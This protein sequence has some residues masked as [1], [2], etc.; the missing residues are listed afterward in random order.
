[1][2][3]RKIVRVDRIGRTTEDA[4][5]FHILRVYRRMPGLFSSISSL[6]EAGDVFSSARRDRVC[7]IHNMIIG[8]LTKK[9]GQPAKGV[10]GWYS[11]SNKN[12]IR[13]VIMGL[14]PDTRCA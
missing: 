12:R 9:Q 2:G 6:L 7:A 14:T 5:R 10:P 13:P 8:G 11:Q 1:M 3:S 4:D